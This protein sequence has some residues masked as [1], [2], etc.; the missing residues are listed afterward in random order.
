MYLGSTLGG[1]FNCQKQLFHC[2][3]YSQIF[4]QWDKSKILK[5]AELVLLT[6]LQ[7]KQQN[8]L[9]NIQIQ[10]QKIMFQNL[11][12]SIHYLLYVVLET[13]DC[14]SQILL[15]IHF[16]IS[17]LSNGSYFTI[18]KFTEIDFYSSRRQILYQFMIQLKTK[19]FTKLASLHSQLREL[20]VFILFKILQQLQQIE[21]KQIFQLQVFDQQDQLV[22]YFTFKCYIFIQ[23][24]IIQSKINQIIKFNWIQFQM[25]LLKQIK[26]LSIYL[27]NFIQ[28]T[29]QNKNFYKKIRENTKTHLS[30]YTS[31]KINMLKMKVYCIQ[32][33]RII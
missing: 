25:Y 16:Q 3:F 9:L 11:L 30:L 23:E 15:K 33:N 32:L 24:Y 8:N 1:I 29:T 2:N 13:Q 5:V 4:Y 22:L 6:Y 27:T 17:I 28:N 31:R 18:P 10:N 7:G 12:K 19:L 21:G 20:L 26:N 14:I